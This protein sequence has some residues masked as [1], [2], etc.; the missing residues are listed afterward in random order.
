MQDTDRKISTDRSSPG[1]ELICED[2]GGALELLRDAGFRLDVIYP[3]DEPRAAI[4]SFD[5]RTVRLKT[6]DAPKLHCS[7]PPFEAEFVLTK[8]GS[9]SIE[10]RAG[11]IYRD[12]I[13]SRLGGRYISSHITITDAGPVADW[14]HYHRIAVQMIYAHRGWVRLVYDGEGEPFVMNEGDIVLQPPKI[15]HRVLESSAGLEVIEITAPAVHETLADHE[16]A[17]PNEARG[18]S[19]YLGQHFVHHLAAGTPWTSFCGGEAQETA[20]KWASNGLLDVRTIRGGADQ[21]SFAPH[22][23]ELVFGLVLDGTAKLEFGNGF[24]LSNADAFVV[25]PQ[26]GWRLRA[27]SS[28]FRLLHVTTTRLDAAPQ[29]L[30]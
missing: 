5:G 24:N 11:M 29:C 16:L 17:L 1:L 15:R 21:M 13:L 12:L 7:L 28:D 27:M 14:V 8:P 9:S 4:L 10:G 2:F 26:Q 30:L 18:N 3:A 25:P 20:M 19:D 23:G 22:D 6:P